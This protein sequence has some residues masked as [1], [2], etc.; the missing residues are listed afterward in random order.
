MANSKDASFY[1]GQNKDLGDF[2]SL[3]TH[4]RKSTV[5][6]EDGKYHL[7]YSFVN[8]GVPVG[9]GS[10]IDE[11]CGHISEMYGT[12]D[13]IGDGIEAQETPELIREMSYISSKDFIST[14]IDFVTVQAFSPLWKGAELTSKYAHNRNMVQG[15]LDFLPWMEKNNY[16][17]DDFYKNTTYACEGYREFIN[18][19][20]GLYTIVTDIRDNAAPTESLMRERDLIQHEISNAMVDE[21]IVTMVHSQYQ[22]AFK[23]VEG[24]TNIRFDQ[25]EGSS[26]P[27]I[28]IN[29]SRDKSNYCEKYSHDVTAFNNFAPSA[30]RSILSTK[31]V[32]LDMKLRYNVSSACGIN[33]LETLKET[34]NSISAKRDTLHGVGHSIG[35]THI[36]D[37]YFNSDLPMLQEKYTCTSLMSYDEETECPYGLIG[38]D[39]AALD[40][41][42]PSA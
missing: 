25:V 11:T 41:L 42:Y 35:L 33:S 4:H 9:P 34:L 40:Y 18:G 38:L 12:L 7:T 16:S 17:K 26:N 37:T 24:L 1:W 36:R 14:V 15:F 10:E 28:L 39:I 19:I 31:Q 13:F 20:G 3:L 32:V 5:P 27:D 22:E 21:D 23:V 6:S 29:L 30:D 2:R 8:S